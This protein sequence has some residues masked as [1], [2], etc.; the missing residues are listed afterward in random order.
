MMRVA[1]LGAGGHTGPC[2]IAEALTR[3]HTVVAIARTPA[4]IRVPDVSDDDPR[5]ERRRGDAFVRDEVVA[6]LRDTDAVITTVGKRDLRDKRYWLNTAAHRHVLE[7][8]RI[9]GIR[10]LV[11][12]SSFGAALDFSRPGLRR[13]IYLFL[14]RRYYGDMQEM[15]RMVTNAPDGAVHVVV[16]A[17][18]LYDTP[19][20]G[21]FEVQEGGNVPGGKTLSRRDLA[22]FVVD[23]LQSNRYANRVVSIAYERA[24][25]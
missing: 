4:N 25:T 18:M 2:L 19:P 13:R 11:A 16:R 10:R 8:M 23:Q 15:E 20:C 22:S 6:A 12:I 1:I 9:H 21:N 24:A 14:R 17:P 3:G 7:G 5:V